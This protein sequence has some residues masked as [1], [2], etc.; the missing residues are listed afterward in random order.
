MTYKKNSIYL[1]FICWFTYFTV[2]AIN[3][4]GVF[5]GVY[6]MLCVT[7]GVMIHDI[8]PPVS[9]SAH[10]HHSDP[11]AHHH[12]VS[13]A[14]H[15]MSHSSHAQHMSLSSSEPQDQSAEDHEAEGCP[16]IHFSFDTTLFLAEEARFIK[17]LESIVDTFHVSPITAVYAAQARGL[18][19]FHGTFH[20]LEQL[21]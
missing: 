16:C 14:D 19:T 2:P 4:I 20:L 1:L 3:S 5:N 13:H 18:P 12:M 17:H 21:T 15:Q 7:R 6:V 11:H 10:L 9:N 8:N